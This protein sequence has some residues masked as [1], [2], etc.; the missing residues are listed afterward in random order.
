MIRNTIPSVEL[1]KVHIADL[2]SRQVLEGEERH[3]RVERE[4]FITS[5]QRSTV[6]WCEFQAR[7]FGEG[8]V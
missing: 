4:L 5:Y 7:H 1:S 8:G 3:G 6:V 2:K